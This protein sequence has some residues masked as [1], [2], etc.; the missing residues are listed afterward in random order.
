MHGS[1]EWLLKRATTVQHIEHNG[2]GKEDEPYEKA[3][4]NC[5]INWDP[6]I[7]MSAI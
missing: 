6:R 4:I 7:K 3:S 2:S 5:L 1:G